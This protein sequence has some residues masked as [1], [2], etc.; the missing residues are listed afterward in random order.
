MLFVE[1]ILLYSLRGETPEEHYKIPLGQADVKRQGTDITVV[2]YSRMAQVC[3]AAAEQL[4]EEGIEIEV[5][6]LRTLRPLDTDTVAESVRKTHR[7][8]VVEETSKLGGF[9]AQVVSDIQSKAFDFLD[10]PVERV[11]GEEVPIPYSSALEKLTIPTPERVA[12]A[13]RG[14]LVQ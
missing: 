6:D 13:V 4:A 9:G 7:A 8:M 14:L 3:L 2:S 10:G 1:H 11:A 5:V 12:Q